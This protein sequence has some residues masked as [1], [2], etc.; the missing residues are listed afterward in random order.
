MRVDRNTP[1]PLYY[2]LQ[3]HFLEKINSRELSAGDRLPSEEEVIEASG[4][5]R[6]TV[7]QAFQALERDGYVERI[8]GKGTFVREPRVPMSV[9]WR[10]LGFSED[11]RR[12]GHTIESRVVGQ[13]LIPCAIE[14][15]AEHLGM[16]A[17]SMVLHIVRERRVDGVPMIHDSVIIRPDLCPGL[18]TTSLDGKSLTGVL[19]EKYKIVVSR[20]HRTLNIV[21]AQPDVA[22]FFAMDPDDGIFMLTDLTFDPTDQPVYFARTAINPRRSEFIFDLTRDEADS[23]TY[24]SDESAH[25]VPRAAKQ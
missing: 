22:E 4:L 2:Q 7:R 15:A 13:K 11:M 3:Q 21:H 20:A 9:A 25:P 16:S 23:G 5:S 19:A 14:S 1:I 17:D 12:K 18:E 10:L 24:V 8:R 6:F